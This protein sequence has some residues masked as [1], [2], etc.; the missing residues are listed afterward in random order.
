MS[1]SITYAFSLLSPWAYLGYEPFLRL[2]AQHGL[3]V[4]YRPMLLSE[5]FSETG[6]L[7]LAKRHPARQAYRWMEMKRWREKRQVPLNLQPRGFPCNIA[8]ADRTLIAIVEAG[9]SPVDFIRSVHR[10]I[11]VEDRQLDDEAVLRDIL[12]ANDLPPG[13]IETAK[14]EAIGA[15]YEGNRDWAIS[16]NIFG[17]PSYVLDGEV[18]WGQDRLELL[19]DM[20]ESGRKPYTADPVT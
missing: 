11:W 10:G 15:I 14:T 7:P 18:F 17:A 13:L 4:V 6:G 1:R 8:P 12:A 5:V 9:L 2:V 16:M 3:T 19:A 20:L